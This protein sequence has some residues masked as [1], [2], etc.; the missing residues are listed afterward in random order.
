M[1]F[2]SVPHDDLL[3]IFSCPFHAYNALRSAYNDVNAPLDDSICHDMHAGPAPRYTCCSLDNSQHSTP[4]R[5]GVDCEFHFAHVVLPFS[6]SA[7]DPNRTM[8]HTIDRSLT[9]FGRDIGSSMSFRCIPVRTGW[10]MARECKHWRSDS[11][12]RPFPVERD[13]ELRPFSMR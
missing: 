10:G 3:M 5:S 12:T 13:H 11:P 4:G 9:R 6:E 2:P 7:S 8:L 1:I